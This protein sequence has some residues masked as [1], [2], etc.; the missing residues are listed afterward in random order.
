MLKGKSGLFV[1]TIFIAFPSLA[2][3]FVFA[4][5]GKEE[6]S[7]YYLQAK[8]GCLA[9]AKKLPNLLNGRID[10]AVTQFSNSLNSLYG[11]DGIIAVGGWR[12]AVG[13]SLTM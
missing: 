10:R 8:D 5:E 3:D 4:I 9:A 7:P 1:I 6:S 11:A 13:H 2:K 12:L